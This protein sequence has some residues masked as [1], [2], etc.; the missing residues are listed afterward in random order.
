[1]Y[2]NSSL[3]RES[4]GESEDEFRQVFSDCLNTMY[5]FEVYEVTRAVEKWKTLNK[6]RKGF[7]DLTPRSP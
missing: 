1:M 4:E 2:S 3:R 5:A 6:E 7:G